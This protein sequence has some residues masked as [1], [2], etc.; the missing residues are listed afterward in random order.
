MGQQCGCP[1]TLASARTYAGQHGQGGAHPASVAAGPCWAPVKV[2]RC[3]GGS[4]DGLH[5][6]RAAPRCWSAYLPQLAGLGAAISVAPCSS[7]T[8]SEFGVSLLLTGDTNCLAGDQR[9]EGAEER[10]KGL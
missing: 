9:Y 5:A 6:R 2:T 3:R 8:V 7:G 4:W 10:S 1:L